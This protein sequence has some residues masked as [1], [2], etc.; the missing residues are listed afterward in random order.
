MMAKRFNIFF[1]K[2]LK[3]NQK[4]YDSEIV[5]IIVGEINKQIPKSLDSV[6]ANLIG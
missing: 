6:G 5:I 4:L 3:I 1:V 2:S